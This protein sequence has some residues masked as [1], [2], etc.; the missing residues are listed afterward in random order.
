MPWTHSGSGGMR[1]IP[2]IVG[3]ERQHLFIPHALRVCYRVQGQAG[4]ER[5]GSHSS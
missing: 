3:V 5:S 1:L 4:V 2:N